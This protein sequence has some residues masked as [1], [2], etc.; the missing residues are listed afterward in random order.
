MFAAALFVSCASTTPMRDLQGIRLGMPRD[1]VRS[2]L[3]STATFGR[4]ERK[5][6]E[7][8][9]LNN[10]PRFAS[11][12]IGYD[13][14]WNVRFVTAVAKEDGPA[15]AYADVIDLQ[16]AEHRSA[17]TSH[18]Y[19]W[20]TGTPPY[21]VIAIGTPERVQYLSLKMHPIVKEE[22]EED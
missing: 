12:I 2:A 19:T 20:T 17:G 7:V 1:E 8:W 6:Q 22:E 15:V 21:S 14:K 5:R 9:T 16:R 10:D 4:Q 13:E 11:L 18:T 3:A